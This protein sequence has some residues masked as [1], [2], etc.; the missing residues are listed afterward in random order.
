MTQK[1]QGLNNL[2]INIDHLQINNLVCNI[3]KIKSF[4][5][6]KFTFQ[7]SNFILIYNHFLIYYRKP[8]D[9]EFLG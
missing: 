5:S 7:Q 6:L 9:Y 2:D 3:K 1:G 4:G 8:A